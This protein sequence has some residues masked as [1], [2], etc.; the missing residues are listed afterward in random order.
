[1][2]DAEV[3]PSI[4]DVQAFLAENWPDVPNHT[5]GNQSLIGIEKAR[6]LLGYK[7]Q[8]GGTHLPLALIWG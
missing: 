5:R 8:P 6:E 1:M 3:D 2:L 4:V 7:P